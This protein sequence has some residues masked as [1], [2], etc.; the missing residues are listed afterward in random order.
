MVIPTYEVGPPE[1]NPIFYSQESY[2]GAQKR[3]YPYP[4]QDHLTQVRT[5]KTY[6]AL[7]LENRFIRLTILPELGGRILALPDATTATSRSISFPDTCS[8]KF[9]TNR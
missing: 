1:P 3:V 4:L 7:K 8:R 9:P 6:K 5:N 2:Q